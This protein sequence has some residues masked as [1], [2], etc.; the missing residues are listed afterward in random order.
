[1]NLDEMLKSSGVRLP[2]PTKKEIYANGDQMI[3]EL[4]SELVHHV[5]RKAERVTGLHKLVL[6]WIYVPLLVFM[7]SFL[8]LV[9]AFAI[10]AM[11]VKDWFVEL[12][13]RLVKWE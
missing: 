10:S 1:M 8:M 12:F 2:R 3:S 4:E 5:K 6:F 7:V 13:H 9:V 11:F